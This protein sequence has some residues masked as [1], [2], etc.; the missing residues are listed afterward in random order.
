MEPKWTTA[1]ALLSIAGLAVATLGM[2]RPSR[3][4]EIDIVLEGDDESAIDALGDALI[5]A[6]RRVPDVDAAGDGLSSA[7]E[8]L[9]RRVWLFLSRAELAELRADIDARWDWEVAH[10]AGWALDDGPPPPV[11]RHGHVRALREWIERLNPVYFRSPDGKALVVVVETKDRDAL[12]HVR[13][14]VDRIHSDH[15]FARVAVEY[16]G[17]GAGP[18]ET[19]HASDIAES[20]LSA[21]AVPKLGALVPADQQAKVADV[22]AIGARMRRARDRGI[23]TDSNWRR[24]E[25]FLPPEDLAPFT[26]DDLL[27]AWN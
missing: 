7:R 6:L 1:L 14:V 10:E 9:E 26:A 24:L 15:R 8:F 2:P 16:A 19:P 12:P 4:S 17:T 22:L 18:E 5:P 27:K 23:I 13:D 11:D 3:T 21:R 20:V 25:P